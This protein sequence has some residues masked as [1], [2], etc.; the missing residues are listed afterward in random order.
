[1]KWVNVSKGSVNESFELWGQDKKLANVS[2]NNNSHIARIVSNLGK[3]LFFFEKRGIFTPKAVFRNEYGIKMGQLELEKPGAQKGYLELDGKRFCYIFNEN[4]SGELEV[5][6]EEMKEK[7][8][9]CNFPQASNSVAKR[10]SLLDTKIPSLLMVLCWYSFQ[11]K[12]SFLSGTNAQN[13]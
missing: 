12:G 10:K 5:Y 4:N 2:F 7:L 11:T 9:N 8:L 1:M 13:N 6:D 3:R